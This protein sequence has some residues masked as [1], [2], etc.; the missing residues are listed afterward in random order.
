[1]CAQAVCAGLRADKTSECGG[2]GRTEFRLVNCGRPGRFG[3]LG[4]LQGCQPRPEAVHS[5]GKQEYNF[6]ILVSVPPARGQQ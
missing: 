1:M 2:Q 5:G 3:T 4:K 6:S